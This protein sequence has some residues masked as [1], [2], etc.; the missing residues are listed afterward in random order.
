M[1]NSE[2]VVNHMLAL[3]LGIDG[4]SIAHTCPGNETTNKYAHCGMKISKNKYLII[5]NQGQSGC[6]WD[7]ILEKTTRDEKQTIVIT[8]NSTNQKLQQQEERFYIRK[9]IQH[10]DK[11]QRKKQ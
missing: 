9:E 4:Q 7:E 10:I 5:R 11:R 1:L 8:A 6:G 3:A 2:Q